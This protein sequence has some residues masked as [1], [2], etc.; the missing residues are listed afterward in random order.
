[1]PASCNTGL[2]DGEFPTDS[3]FGS[4]ARVKFSESSGGPSWTR[5][6]SQWIKTALKWLAI[7]LVVGVVAAFVETLMIGPQE[8]KTQKRAASSGRSRDEQ[9]AAAGQR[10]DAGS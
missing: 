3:H 4:K 9:R 10:N 2:A 5:T 7:L 8:P 1:M 6:R